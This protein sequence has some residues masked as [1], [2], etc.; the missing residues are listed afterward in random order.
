MPNNEIAIFG[1]GVLSKNGDGTDEGQSRGQCRDQYGRAAGH[2]NHGIGRPA[3]AQPEC[4]RLVG[5]VG[6][7]S[8][9]G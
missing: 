5:P 1:A 6:Q 2:E 8:L 3:D 9:I 4:G 7:G